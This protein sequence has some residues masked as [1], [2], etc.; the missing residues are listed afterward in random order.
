MQREKATVQYDNL[1]NQLNP[2]FLFNSLSS[3][4]SLIQDDQQLASDFLQHLSK[5]YR[6]VLQ[7]KD[8]ETVSIQTELDFIRNYV[9]LLE[10]RF[11]EGFSVNYNLQPDDLEREIVPVT[12]QI[13]IENAVKHN[14]ITASKP[15]MLEIASDGEFII[16][17]N[18]L[19]KKSNVETSNKQGMEKLKTLYRYITQKQIVVEETAT[20][21]IVKLPLV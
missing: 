15:L 9:F 10:T 3:L 21:F 8:K 4:N 1:T 2:H 14:I 19:Q 12:L 11:Q 17:K 7:N 18:T 6:Y 20:E 16:V 5:V 13:L